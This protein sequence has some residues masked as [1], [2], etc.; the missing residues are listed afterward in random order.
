MRWLAL[1]LN[2]IGNMKMQLLADRKIIGVKVYLE[3][4]K[5]RQFVG[6]LIYEKADKQFIFTYDK[7]YIYSD[8]IIPLG[9]DIP[10]TKEK[11]TSKTLFPSLED[12]IPSRENPAY[13]DYCQAMGITTKERDPIIL[14]VTIGRRGPSSFIFEPHY[15]C[16][17]DA[18]ALRAF[19]K[20]MGLT[21]REFSECFEMTQAT[22]VNIESG[23]ASGKETLK[24]I[25][26]YTHFPEAIYYQLQLTGGILHTDKLKKVMSYLRIKQRV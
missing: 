20:E 6:E 13:K 7:K 1:F 10:L 14:L 3:K 2:D 19:R 8:Y 9:P 25:E 5:T 23:K 21:T 18:A 17:F 22:L 15:E 16:K 24:R 26:L 4:R 12:R 11:H